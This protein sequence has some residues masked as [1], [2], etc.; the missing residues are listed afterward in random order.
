M[1]H[2]FKLF[3]SFCL[4]NI[5]DFF[6]NL[7]TIQAKEL[8]FCVCSIRKIFAPLT[9]YQPNWTTRSKVS[10]FSNFICIVSKTYDVS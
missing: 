5:G 2:L 10:N 4:Y 6:N 9:N 8:K 7:F 1:A 3:N